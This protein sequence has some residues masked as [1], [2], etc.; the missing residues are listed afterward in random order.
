MTSMICK[1]V[2]AHAELIEPVEDEAETDKADEVGRVSGS[3][4]ASRRVRASGFPLN[5][6]PCKESPTSDNLWKCC[7]SFKALSELLKTT[8]QVHACNVLHN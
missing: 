6:C 8:L 3:E 5:V 2:I 4:R 1:K 7:W